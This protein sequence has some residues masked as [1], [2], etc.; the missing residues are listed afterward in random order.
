M[1]K[2]FYIFYDHIFQSPFYLIDI[3]LLHYVFLYKNFQKLL[4]AWIACAV[5]TGS[6]AFKGIHSESDCENAVRSKLSGTILT[7]SPFYQIKAP[8]V[9][10]SD[11][12]AKGNKDFRAKKSRRRPMHAQ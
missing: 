3:K 8:N 5:P 9:L 12:I 11:R 2:N 7:Q 10:A 4:Y 6:I 1:Q